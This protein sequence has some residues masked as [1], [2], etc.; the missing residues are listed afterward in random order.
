MGH[1]Y[2]K[3]I[4]LFG[5]F[6]AELNAGPPFVSSSKQ[7]RFPQLAGQGQLQ[8]V[9]ERPHIN[10]VSVSC[11]PDSLE[12][13]IQADLF[14]V[15]ASVQSSDLRLG[16]DHNERCKAVLSSNHEYRITAGLLD[17][18]TKHW[19]TEE[20]LVYTNLL[21][22]SPEPSAGVIRME[23]AVIP[24][25]CH[26][27]RKYS[28]ISPAL[29]P[30]WVPFVSTMAAM[31]KL[32]F[33]LK[34]MTPDWLYKRSSNVF[35]LGEPINMRLQSDLD[36]TWAS[37]CFSALVWPLLLQKP[38][39]C[40][41]M[42]S[43]KMDLHHMQMTAVPVNDADSPNKA[44]TFI[45][46][47]WR[48]ADGNDFLCGYCQNQNEESHNQDKIGS[49]FSA[50]G[51]GRPTKPE[52][53]WKERDN[54]ATVGPLV[55]LPLEKKT[56]RKLNQ[57]FDGS[58]WRSG[59]QNIVEK[60]LVLDMSSSLEEDAENI[61]EPDE[62]IPPDVIVGDSDDAG[63][64][65]TLKEEDPEQSFDVPS[66]KIAQDV[67]LK[68][69]E[70]LEN[71]TTDSI[72]VEERDD[73]DNE[74]IPGYSQKI[75]LNCYYVIYLYQ[76]TRSESSGENVAWNQRRTDSTTSQD[77][78]SLT[79][80]DSSLP[81]E[82]EPELRTYISRR[83][84]KGA[85]LG[86][87]GN[88]ATVELSIPEQAV[89]CYCCLLEQERSPEQP[90]SDG[91][92]YVICFMGGSEKGLNLYPY[93]HQ[94][95]FCLV[96]SMRASSCE[97][98][99]HKQTLSN[100]FTKSTFRLELD[101]Y[102]QGLHSS[103][104]TPE[105]QNLETEVR[106]YLSRWYEESVMHIY[107]VVQLV[108]ANISFLLHAALSHTPV[109]VVN[110]DER[111]KADV[112]RFIKAASLQGL[113]QQQDTTAASLC[114]AMSED[115]QT[116]LIIDCATNPPTLS[117]TVSNRFCDDWIQAFLNAAERCNPFLLRQ[118][119]ENFKLKAIQDMNSLKRFVRQAE[120]SHYAL[121][122]CCQFLQS[123]GNGDVLLQNTRAEH[124]DSTEACSIISVLEEFIREQTQA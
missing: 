19:M 8:T 29:L 47:R 105:L 108:Q 20:S 85:L 1:W 91:N 4:V 74:D 38:T 107:R 9:D 10:S 81:V 42:C 115:V 21:I 77:D 98:I 93:I 99:V 110:S 55:V 73:F 120:M 121:F 46:G 83:L 92:G 28:L 111:T 109:E 50:R 14:G 26:Y 40:R 67:P 35:Y 78:F 90:E 106:P 117:N 103:L 23:E 25:E 30:T 33:D 124:S 87:M 70:V 76:G 97:K 52:F 58:K 31:E 53:L 54:E 79:L 57:L 69:N 7:K 36:I 18:G 24:V 11:H 6:L 45:N 49:K 61:P 118:I 112:S 48:S 114:K 80:I 60:E 100:S 12:V 51:F 65:E 72:D 102:V 71:E 113:S 88:I 2:F 39:L 101:K 86:G 27:E 16:V 75:Q 68:T 89:G 63:G 96:W 95:Y 64:N 104:Q 123:C 119:L 22:Y 17:C 82:A 44:C 13:V 15:G 34:I 66:E 43:L 3:G 32:S 84:S 37:G 41:D 94:H 5:L 59:V 116:D 56:E 62:E 122:R